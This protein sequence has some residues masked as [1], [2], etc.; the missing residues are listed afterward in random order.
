MLIKLVSCQVTDGVILG[1][2]F[3]ILRGT[4]DGGVTGMVT[5]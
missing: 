2:D 3:G 1:S 5:N 4:I